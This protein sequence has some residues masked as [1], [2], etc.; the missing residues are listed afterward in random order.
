MVRSTL[1]SRAKMQKVTTPDRDFQNR[2]KS[3]SSW[4]FVRIDSFRGKKS[5]VEEAS[6]TLNHPGF[7]FKSFTVAEKFGSQSRKLAIMVTEKLKKSIFL[8]KFPNTFCSLPWGFGALNHSIFCARDHFY[9]F[10]IRHEIFTKKSFMFSGSIW[11]TNF[12]WFR[13][14]SEVRWN[15][16]CQPRIQREKICRFVITNLDS[17]QIHSSMSV[18]LYRN[19]FVHAESAS[20]PSVCWWTTG[21]HSAI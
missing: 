9:R 19:E 11:S 4:P 2:P 10:G 20:H 12:E 16:Q 1:R 6:T 15:F 18:T 21:Q 5:P 13:C 7:I 3:L 17:I 14:G 8:E